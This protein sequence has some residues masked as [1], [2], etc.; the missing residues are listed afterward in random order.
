MTADPRILDRASFLH[1]LSHDAQLASRLDHFRHDALE[2]LGQ[3]RRYIVHG[4]LDHVRSAAQALEA[5]CAGVGAEALRGIAQA[6]A[7]AAFAQDPAKVRYL[8][9]DLDDELERL[10][11]LIDGC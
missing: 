2:R 3:M 10:E 5:A 9:L 7:R 1:R 4:K 8:L 11:R 6:M